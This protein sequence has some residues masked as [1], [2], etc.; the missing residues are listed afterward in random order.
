[1]PVPSVLGCRL[2]H[3]HDMAYAHG[4]LMI[5]ARAPVDLAGLVGLY[6]THLRTASAET[7]F[8][9]RSIAA[10]RRPADVVAGL[11]ASPARLKRLSQLWHGHCDALETVPVGLLIRAHAYSSTVPSSHRR[12]ATH[13]PDGS[14]R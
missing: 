6:P 5:A 2:G 9:R 13:R 8:H 1:M 11:P 12:S 4:D 3:H 7:R 14:N 10:N